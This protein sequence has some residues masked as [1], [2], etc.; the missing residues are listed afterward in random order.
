M[1]GL[2]DTHHSVTREA[3]HLIPQHPSKRP[4][5][6]GLHLLPSALLTVPTKPMSYLAL[7]VTTTP[8]PQYLE[9]RSASQPTNLT[10]AH[11][12]SL[13][14]KLTGD[15]KARTD[16]AYTSSQYITNLT[17]AGILLFPFTVDHLGGLGHHAHLFLYGTNH[18]PPPEPPPSWVQRLPPHAA[19]TYSLLKSL[20]QSLLPLATTAH[21]TSATEPF[22]PPPPTPPA[23]PRH[24][25]VPPK[26]PDYTPTRWAQQT[27]ALNFT[28]ALAMHLHRARTNALSVLHQSH[29][30]PLLCTATP[31]SDSSPD[32][33][34]NPFPHFLQATVAE[35]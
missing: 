6:V 29:A 24:L 16:C 11:L 26:V 34:L 23:P 17:D 9:S 21:S 15:D 28:T 20:P 3:K 18:K 13:R 30:S 27:L 4:A 12:S 35:A 22:D 31:Y 19:L 5:D 7:D 14:I 1:A 2:T 33:V 25:S 32:P 10:K 8:S